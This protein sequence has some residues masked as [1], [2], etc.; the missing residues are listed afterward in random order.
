MENVYIVSKLFGIEC[1]SVKK[2]RIQVVFI[3]SWNF[4]FVFLYCSGYGYNCIG[5]VIEWIKCMYIIK[6]FKRK[7]FKV[8]KEYYDVD[9][10]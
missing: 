4:N 2:S 6:I 3:C 5:S 10:L 8:L 7:V 1:D 9:F